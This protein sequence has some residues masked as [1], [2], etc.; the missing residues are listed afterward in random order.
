MGTFSIDEKKAMGGRAKTGNRT[1]DLSY[2]A[3]CAVRL[4]HRCR[5]VG[6]LLHCRGGE[7]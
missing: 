4:R 7:A 5:S 3:M 2:H 1:L 6:G